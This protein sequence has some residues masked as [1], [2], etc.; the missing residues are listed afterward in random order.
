M[1]SYV[2]SL[3]APPLRVTGLI[4]YILHH[5]S[6]FSTKLN[7]RL[8]QKK[9]STNKTLFIEQCLPES[10]SARAA[11][12]EWWR[13]RPRH[14]HHRCTRQQECAGRPTRPGSAYVCETQA[15]LPAA[16]RDRRGR[17]HRRIWQDVAVRETVRHSSSP[18][19][20]SRPSVPFPQPASKLPIIQSA[21]Q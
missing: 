2:S 20:R 9:K 11:R 13:R 7:H 16:E 18:D 1:V 4:S 12:L 5:K 15:V 8:M 6:S 14:S 17:N 10:S 3:L 19:G 21:G